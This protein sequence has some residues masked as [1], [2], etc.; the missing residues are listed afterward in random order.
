MMAIEG[1]KEE[2]RERMIDGFRTAPHKRC[3][4]SLRHFRFCKPEYFG[5]LY[6]GKVHALGSGLGDVTHGGG[7]HG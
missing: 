4:F 6:I 1:F 5:N 7:R 3:D 2:S